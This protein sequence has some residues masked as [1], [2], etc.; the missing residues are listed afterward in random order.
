LEHSAYTYIYTYIYIHAYIYILYYDFWITKRR[1][2]CII[3]IFM[4]RCVYI[5]MCILV[6]GSMH[7]PT[8]THSVAPEAEQTYH[9]P[10]VPTPTT[11]VPHRPTDPPPYPPHP[12]LSSTH[13]FCLAIP[14]PPLATS[15][16]R[17]PTSPLFSSRSAN[18]RNAA[19]RRNARMCS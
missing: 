18:E 13:F 6:F 12:H 9:F 7:P 5:Y 16:P 14:H 3:G 17:H 8:H 10:P 2:L 15:P 1:W 19:T 4:C 11:P